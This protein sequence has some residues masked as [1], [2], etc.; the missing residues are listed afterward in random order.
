MDLLGNPIWKNAS[1]AWQ[2]Q[3]DYYFTGADYQRIEAVIQ[4][5]EAEGYKVY[6]SHACRFRALELTPLSEVRCV[7]LGQDP[8]HKQGQANGLAFSVNKGSKM[9]PSLKN[10]LIE[11]RND[12]SQKTSLA[13]DNHGDLSVW[14]K[15][16]VLLLNTLLTVREAEPLS[17]QNTGW[18]SLSRAVI[19][20]INTH[21]EGVVFVLWGSA[22]RAYKPC[23]NTQKHFVIEGAHPSPLSA[24]RGFFGSKPFSKVN[25]YLQ[26]R[27]EDGIVW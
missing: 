14:A 24:Y 27:G 6:P 13:E 17:H 4:H 3:L 22:A 25:E 5:D 20:A 18:E 19:E 12:Y 15:Q 2:N 23:V 7:I 26:K 8:Y 16:G 9:P 11:L 10:L 21:K 1:N